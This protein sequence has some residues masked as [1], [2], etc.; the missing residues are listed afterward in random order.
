M[1]MVIEGNPWIWV[2]VLNPGGNEQFLGQ[3]DKQDNVSFIPAFLEKEE[4]TTCLKALPR[5]EGVKYEVQAV[6]YEELA[7]D[8]KKN[9]FMIFLLND[10]GEIRERIAP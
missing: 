4:A 6:Q 8:A 2:G 7:R 3:H 5:D 1:S 9:G 10:A